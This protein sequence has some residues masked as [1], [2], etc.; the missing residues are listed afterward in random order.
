MAA[1]L[2]PHCWNDTS[3][4]EPE[5]VIEVGLPKAFCAA[6]MT[7][8]ASCAI[9]IPLEYA[10]QIAARASFFNTTSPPCTGSTTAGAGVAPVGGSPAPRRMTPVGRNHHDNEFLNPSIRN[11]L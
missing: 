6:A 4:A 5:Y 1:A 3:L 9:A 10:R 8:L 7:A 11:G 2:A